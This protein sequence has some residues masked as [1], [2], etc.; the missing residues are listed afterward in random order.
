MIWKGEGEFITYLLYEAILHIQNFFFR[1]IAL[2]ALSERLSKSHQDRSPLIP[3]P[4]LKVQIPVPKI[5]QTPTPSTSGVH[6]HHQTVILPSLPN[7][8]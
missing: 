1:Q 5:M 6:T 3:K 2:K 7:N 8:T 4:N